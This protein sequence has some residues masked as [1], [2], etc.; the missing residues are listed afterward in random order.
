MRGD[1]SLNQD[2]TC[3]SREKIGFALAAA[4]NQISSYE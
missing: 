3:G 2:E 1:W 4:Q